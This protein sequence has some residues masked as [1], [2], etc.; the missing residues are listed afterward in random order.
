MA[1]PD[2]KKLHKDWK[3]AKS[4]AKLFYDE[5]VK[6]NTDL[7]NAHEDVKFDGPKFP[8]FNLDLGPSLEKIHKQKD[9]EKNKTKANKAVTQYE[10]DIDSLLKKVPKVE[11]GKDQKKVKMQSDLL[12]I[13]NKLSKVRDEIDD[14]LETL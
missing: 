6:L 9:V 4:D 10:K 7:S 3:K 12:K 5:W 11:T 14:A 8:K 13:L 2:F 1:A